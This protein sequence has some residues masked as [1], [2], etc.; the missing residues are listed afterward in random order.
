VFPAGSKRLMTNWRRLDFLKLG[1]D[2][3][4]PRPL[5]AVLVAGALLIS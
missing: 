3:E 4:V 5:K 1:W 2:P